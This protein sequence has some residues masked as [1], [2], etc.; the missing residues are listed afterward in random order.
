MRTMPVDPEMYR[1]LET[2]L[3]QE[4]FPAAFGWGPTSDATRARASLPVR[5]G[6]LALPN[7]CLLA[8]SERSNSTA[9][10][11]RLLDAVI[12]Q[13]WTFQVDRDALWDERAEREVMRDLA[14]SIEADEIERRLGGAE[15]RSLHETR[16]SGGARWLAAIP[17]NDFNC[18]YALPQQ[19]FRDAVA[20]QMGQPLPDDLPSH[21]PSCDEQNVDVAHFL[22]CPKKGWVRRRH[23]EVLKELARLMRGVC[24]KTGVIEEPELGPV[25]GPPFAN[26]NTTT[27]SGARTDILARGFFEPQMDAHFD[28]TIID[29]AQK[30]ALKKGI[31][32]ETLLAEA[33]REKRDFYEERVKRLGGSFTPFA[34]SVYGTLAPESERVILT[35]M[36]KMS[37]ENGRRA[38]SEACARLRI[39]IAIVKATSLCIRSRSHDS[40]KLGA[41]ANGAQMDEPEVEDSEET[42]DLEAEWGDLRTTL[43]Q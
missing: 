8:E 33:Q 9:A 11:R 7:P 36:S 22:K 6:G 21:C 14:L 38:P 5:H 13:D 41:S 2:R 20:L 37:K 12:Q 42:L 35:L 25:R 43:G 40:N 32:P 4:F 3:A 26:K 23:T 31:K 28:V 15:Q 10:V 16:L 29:T 18:R 19:V 39:Q 17:L 1:P 30:S 27:D 24:G 34:A